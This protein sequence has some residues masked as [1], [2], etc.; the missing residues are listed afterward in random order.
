MARMYSRKRGRAGSKRPSK[1]AI[2]TWVSYK[3]EEIDKLILK[4]YKSGNSISKVGMILRD[5]YG[6][7]S[8]RYITKN[9]I[10]KILKTNNSAPKLPEDI[11]AL[12]KKDIRLVK[13]LDGNKKDMTVWRGLQITE[14]KINKLAKYYKREKVLPSDWKFD[15]KTAKLFI[16]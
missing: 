6:I 9:R 2:P 14:S 11:T 12:I 5:N 4:L 8:V 3:S 16:E 7:P 10:G 1:I 13:H 15:R